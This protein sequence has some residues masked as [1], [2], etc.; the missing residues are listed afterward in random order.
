MA[1]LLT[2]MPDDSLW[3]GD[4]LRLVHNYDL[5]PGSE[6]VDLLVYDPHHDDA[7]MGVVVVSGYKA[8]LTLSIFPAASCGAGKRSLETAWLLRHWNDWFCYTYPRN[9]QDEMIPVPV[10]GTLVIRWDEREISIR[11]DANSRSA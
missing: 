5:G 8:G 1:R 2:E 10:E 11:K 7:G 9:D 4:I 3:S 6:P